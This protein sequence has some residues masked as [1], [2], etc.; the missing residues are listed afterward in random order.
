[1]VLSVADEVLI[2]ADE[3]LSQAAAVL[4]DSRRW[5]PRVVIVVGVLAVAGIV[6][7]VIVR[8]RRRRAED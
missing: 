8:G 4:A 3:A 7:A 6:T 1:A 5:A 2:K